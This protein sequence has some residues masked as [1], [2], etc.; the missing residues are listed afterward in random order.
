VR[1]GCPSRRS[2]RS[3]LFGRQAWR[4]NRADR[5]DL[6]DGQPG[7]N[8]G[9]PSLAPEQ[10]AQTQEA[11]QVIKGFNEGA[12]SL[13]PER[14]PPA[15]LPPRPAASMRGRQA[16]RPNASAFWRSVPKGTA[17]MRGRQAW[18]PNQAGK[19]RPSPTYALQ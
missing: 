14:H 5:Q 6:R 19:A 1:P 15:P 9:A 8:E 3:A 13:A 18:R 10:D 7:F 16:W 4:P 2:W 17:S 11:V 12:P